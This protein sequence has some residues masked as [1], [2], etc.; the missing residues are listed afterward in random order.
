MTL[1][2]SGLS[3]LPET[4]NWE[5]LRA[6]EELGTTAAA[7]DFCARRLRV[8]A[9]DVLLSS[10]GFEQPADCPLSKNCDSPDVIS[11]VPKLCL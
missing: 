7:T 5:M 1:T 6:T 2:F 11:S 9:S 4:W 10:I 8:Q 3:M